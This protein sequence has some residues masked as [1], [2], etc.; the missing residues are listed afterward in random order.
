MHIF[1]KRRELR[2]HYTAYRSIKM[3]IQIT[4]YIK[5]TIFF[6][7]RYHVN[8][9]KSRSFSSPPQYQKKKKILELK[10]R[11]EIATTVTNKINDWHACIYG[12]TVQDMT[13]LNKL[14]F[15]NLNDAFSRYFF[16]TSSL[17]LY[18]K[19]LFFHQWERKIQK[20][21]AIS[22]LVSLYFNAGKMLWI[23]SANM[24]YHLLMG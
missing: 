21:Y 12:Y 13:E 18:L 16:L 5:T 14:S 20:C 9:R 1:T 22:D 6:N 4:T 2:L 3:L 17:H 24:N 19:G 10:L 11:F 15:L 23:V 8:C 7:N